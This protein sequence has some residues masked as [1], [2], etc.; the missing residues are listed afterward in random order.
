MRQQHYDTKPTTRDQLF[1]VIAKEP[2]AR[3]NVSARLDRAEVLDCGHLS[4]PPDPSIG[5]ASGYAVRPDQTRICYACADES[6]REA[7]KTSDKI[8]AY[9]SDAVTEPKHG[10]TIR[11]SEITTWTGGHLMSIVSIVWRRVGFC[12]VTGRRPMSA[13]I[14][15]RDV[16]GAVWIGRSPGHGMYARMR[17]AKRSKRS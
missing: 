9:L 3:G 11:P 6:E 10:T 17:R 13:F 12:D 1:E 2:H 14:T 16:H 4:L 15:A 7:L 8:F 5:G